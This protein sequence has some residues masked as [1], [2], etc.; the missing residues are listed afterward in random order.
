MKS[1]FLFLFFF[2]FLIFAQNT[3]DLEV[4]IRGLSNNKGK[5]YVGLYNSEEQFLKKAFVGNISKIAKHEA[6]VTFKNVPAGQYALSA[7][8]DKND[9]GKL[10]TNMIGV[11]KE[12]Y[13]VSNNAKNRFS[14]PKYDKAKFDLTNKTRIVLSMK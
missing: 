9:N 10:D 7:F 1:I 2:P 12:D 4:V 6:I 3:Y 8:H 13:T 14:A 11:P 5:V